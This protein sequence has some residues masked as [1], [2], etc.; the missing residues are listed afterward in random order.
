MNRGTI[1]YVYKDIFYMFF[2]NAIFVNAGSWLG[3][4]VRS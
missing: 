2:L 4:K 1:F 3:S